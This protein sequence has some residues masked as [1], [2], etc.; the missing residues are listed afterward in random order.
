MNISSIF[1]ASGGFGT[2]PAYHAAKGAVRIL[3][4]NAALHWA[5]ENV[6]V[7]SVQAAA[8]PPKS[9]L[10][11]DDDHRTTGVVNAVLADRTEQ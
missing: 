9:L 11:T 8:S 4:K 7:N 5:L 1:G 6:R 3:T 2:S 10:A